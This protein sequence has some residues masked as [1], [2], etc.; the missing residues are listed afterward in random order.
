MAKFVIVIVDDF[1]VINIIEIH[2]DNF[3]FDVV[4]KCENV[5]LK[6]LI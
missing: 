4:D 6:I 1:L 3:T 2:L 5:R